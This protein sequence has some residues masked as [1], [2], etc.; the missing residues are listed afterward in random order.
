M[1]DQLGE[2]SRQLKYRQVRSSFLALRLEIS[3]FLMLCFH[4]Q[5]SLDLGHTTERS[6]HKAQPHIEMD[7]DLSRGTKNFNFFPFFIPFC[8]LLANNQITLAM[9]PELDLDFTLGLP[10]YKTSHKGGK[11]NRGE[12]GQSPTDTIPSTS[13]YGLWVGIQ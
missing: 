8:L 13:R 6:A 2:I 10:N 1:N 11:N 12:D 4:E 9:A 7:F 5:L 3:S